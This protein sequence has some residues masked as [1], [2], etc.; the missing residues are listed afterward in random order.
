MKNFSG[1]LSPHWIENWRAIAKKLVCIDLS[2]VQLRWKQA[3]AFAR[4]VMKNFPTMVN[5]ELLQSI[6]SPSTQNFPLPILL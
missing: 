6:N 5:L 3:I 4:G 2:P 1:M